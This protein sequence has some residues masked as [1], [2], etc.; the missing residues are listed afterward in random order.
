MQLSGN[1]LPLQ[2]SP[3][4]AQRSPAPPTTKPGSAANRARVQLVQQ[5]DRAGGR[6]GLARAP[7]ARAR[8]VE[9]ACDQDVYDGQQIGGV[10]PTSRVGRPPAPGLR[11][12]TYTICSRGV[13]RHPTDPSP[14]G[15][16]TSRRPVG[17]RRVARTARAPGS[18]GSAGRAVRQATAHTDRSSRTRPLQPVT[19]RR[20]SLRPVAGKGE[21]PSPRGR[22]SVE[23]PKT[24]GC[25]GSVQ[26]PERADCPADHPSPRAGR[27]SE[28]GAANSA[29]L[30]RSRQ[31]SRTGRSSDRRARRR[32]PGESTRSTD[33]GTDRRV[34]DKREVR[35]VC[36]HSE[37]TR[38]T[39]RQR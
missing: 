11:C 36:L 35:D 32:G 9:S 1:R 16:N 15:P 12:T 29:A 2:P 3:R 10:P 4:A 25:H 26:R 27:P 39:S 22:G 13:P 18:N 8:P 37:P 34:A 24:A 20:S 17:C 6:S 5:P 14:T 19:G 31:V 30:G 28:A 7:P 38:A 21:H 33:H 23:P